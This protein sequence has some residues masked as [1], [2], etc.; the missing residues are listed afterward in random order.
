MTSEHWE[1]ERHIELLQGAA[2]TIRSSV[3]RG[4]LL[5]DSV[6][7][8]IDSIRAVL[9]DMEG[10]LAGR[11]HVVALGHAS[12]PAPSSTTARV[13]ITLFRSSVVADEFA[14]GRLASGIT[15][16]TLIMCTETGKETGRHVMTFD[17]HKGSVTLP[18]VRRGTPIFCQ[19][20]LPDKSMRVYTTPLVEIDDALGIAELVKTDAWH[21]R[22]YRIVV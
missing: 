21:G 6:Q 20:E 15:G 13:T 5:S 3:I 4:A 10:T 12:A 17:V 19:F 16:A 14:K 1:L 7:P 18:D 9:A 2:K 11:K 8:A 22:V